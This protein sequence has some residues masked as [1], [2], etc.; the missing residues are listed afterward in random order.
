MFSL[1]VSRLSLSLCFM[2]ASLSPL[3][4]HLHFFLSLPLPWLLI[5]LS[6]ILCAVLSVDQLRTL[7]FLLFWV[8]YKP[9]ISNQV[10]PQPSHSLQRPTLHHL[11]ALWL[12]LHPVVT[13]A[14]PYCWQCMF[15]SLPNFIILD[16][17]VIF[18]SLLL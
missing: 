13:E 12:L 3:P 9:H 17:I 16:L 4:L 5:S 10:L 6:V 7:Q 2:Y 18:L 8:V 11:L 15:F 14:V 1:S